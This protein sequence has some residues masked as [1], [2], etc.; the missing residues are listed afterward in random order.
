MCYNLR[1][2]SSSKSEAPPG[3]GNP[4][5]LTPLRIESTPSL[6]AGRIREGI[7]AGTIAPGS[8]LNEVE[9]TRSLGI[10]RGPDP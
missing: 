5:Q 4:G 9:L 10:S 1:M 8:Q 7:F 2:T 3:S 6:V